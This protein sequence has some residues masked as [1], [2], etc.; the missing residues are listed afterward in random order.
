[1]SKCVLEEKL[2]APVDSLAYPFGKPRRH[3]DR[4][5]VELAA[6]AGY[7]SGA[8][9]LFR[10]AKPKDHAL[11]IPRFFA[12]ESCPDLAAQVRGDWDWLGAWQERVPPRL[13]KLVSPVDFEA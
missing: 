6:E 4:A 1:V 12:N 8:A 10:G 13:A 3:F 11:A 2:G 7:V 9:V 5:V